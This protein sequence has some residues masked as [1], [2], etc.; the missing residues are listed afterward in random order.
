MT[1]NGHEQRLAMVNNND[2][3]LVRRRRLRHARFSGSQEAPADLEAITPLQQ[4][5]LAP[6]KDYIINLSLSPPTQEWTIGYSLT[7]ASSGRFITL[8]LKL[9]LGKLSLVSRCEH[10]QYFMQR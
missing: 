3:D 9:L 6:L 1:I 4:P 5:E 10:L 8:L 7:R 2:D